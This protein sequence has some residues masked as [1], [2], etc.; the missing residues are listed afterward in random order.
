MFPPE[1]LDVGGGAPRLSRGAHAGTLESA[2]RLADTAV[3]TDVEQ[4]A[5]H[6]WGAGEISPTVPWFFRVT[7]SP[8]PREVIGLP[9]TNG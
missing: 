6:L 9:E 2:L 4:D 5:A 8:E 1:K 3:R 7:L